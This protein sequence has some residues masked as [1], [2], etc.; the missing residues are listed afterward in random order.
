MSSVDIVFVGASPLSFNYRLFARTHV[1]N[2]S[3]PNINFDLTT[4]GE[5]PKVPPMSSTARGN[6]LLELMQFSKYLQ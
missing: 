4:E 1:P 6:V 5:P 2:I 3:L